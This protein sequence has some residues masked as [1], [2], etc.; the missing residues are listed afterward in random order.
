[1]Y[2]LIDINNVVGNDKNAK[3]EAIKQ[4]FRAY[5]SMDD[6]A[7]DKV[8]FLKK[9]YD[10]DENDDIATFTS[11]LTGANKGKRRYA[12]AKNYNT[13]LTNVY[14]KIAKGQEGL[15]INWK[16]DRP[17]VDVAKTVKEYGPSFASMILTGNPSSFINK[18]LGGTT[19]SPRRV[20]FEKYLK[21]PKYS[22]RK[23][24]VDNMNALQDS[25]IGRNYNEPQ[26]LAFLASVGDESGGDSKS[27][28]STGEFKGIIQWGS[29]RYSGTE[30]LGEQIHYMLN[31]AETLKDPGWNNGG[32]GIPTTPTAKFAYDSFWKSATP[33]SA[34]FYLNKGYVRP[35]EEHDRVRRAEQASIMNKYLEKKRRGGVIKYQEPAQGINRS[36]IRT[37][38]DRK[39]PKYNRAVYSS[40]NP[41]YKMDKKL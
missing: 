24:L 41:I 14:N 12:E 3:G 18:I 40:V 7:K 4:K 9:L 37:D 25:L 8:Q 39:V 21:D 32:K 22:K 13:L 2:Y 29:D 5:N 26:R 33:D 1:M 31:E 30:D 20:N 15:K 6:Y 35:R 10:F 28:D 36:A 27:V 11:K 23:F 34:T 19:D 17:S 38:E 16:P